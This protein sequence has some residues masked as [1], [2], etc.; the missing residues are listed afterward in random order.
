MQDAEQWLE[1]CPQR[2]L[3]NWLAYYRLEPFGN[4]SEL[5]SKIIGLLFYLCRSK[6]GEVEEI[7]KFVE[8]VQRYVMPSGWIGQQQIVDSGTVTVDELKARFAKAQK[9]AEKAFG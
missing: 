9:Q 3:D 5:L 2:V 8:I 4:E 6:G 1:D 7:Q